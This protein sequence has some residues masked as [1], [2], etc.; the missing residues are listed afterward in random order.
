M[1]VDSVSVKAELSHDDT[2]EISC[3]SPT[4]V[5]LPAPESVESKRHTSYQSYSTLKKKIGRF[6]SIIEFCSC[7][8]NV[9][10]AFAKY[11]H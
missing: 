9:S 2:L 5:Q 4:R 6:D 3:Y 10:S 8:Q 11:T 1:G 7:L